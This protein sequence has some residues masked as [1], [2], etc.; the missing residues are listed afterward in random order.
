[1]KDSFLNYFQTMFNTSKTSSRSILS[2]LNGI[3]TR[4]TEPMRVQ[5]DAT[6]TAEEVH[7]ALFGM[8]PW[9]ALGADGFHAGFFQSNCNLVGE[10]TSVFLQGLNGVSAIGDLNNIFLVLIPKVK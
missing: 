4:V 8:S 5:L 3:E 2:A 1:M 6:Y 9:K 10:Q 7:K